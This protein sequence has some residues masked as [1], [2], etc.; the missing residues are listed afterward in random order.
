MPSGVGFELIIVGVLL[1]ILVSAALVWRRVAPGKPEERTSN[2]ELETSIASPSRLDGEDSRGVRTDM[3]A[4]FRSDPGLSLTGWPAVVMVVGAPRSGRTTMVAKLGH[5]LV[6]RGRLVAMTTLDLSRGAAGHQLAPLAERAGADLLVLE[7]T[8]DPG[9]A[10]YEAVAAARG[11]GSDVLILDTAGSIGS[12]QWSMSEIARIRRVLERA[13][14]QV[15][16]VLLV[17][18]A[19]NGPAAI[20]EA[21]HLVEAAGVTGIALSHLDRTG[22]PRIALAVREELGIPVKLVGAGDQIDSLRSFDADWFARLLIG[23]E[24]EAGTPLTP[25][26]LPSASE[27]PSSAAGS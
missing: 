15:G 18:D 12:D 21:R 8:T 4:S 7:R 25:D 1:A 14:G 3:G 23:G 20:T 17:F 5:R 19:R 13:A 16:E 2:D 6:N 10:A 26:W 24:S 27:P 22:E 11:R 9:A